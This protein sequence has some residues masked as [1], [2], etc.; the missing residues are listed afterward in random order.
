MLW[1]RS[2]TRA[3]HTAETTVQNHLAW[4][5]KLLPIL[6][7]HV[8]RCCHNTFVNT[9][10]AAARWNWQT[11]CQS[12]TTWNYAGST[13]WASHGIHW[14][15]DGWPGPGGM[16]G[17]CLPIGLPQSEL[18][19]CLHTSITNRQRNYNATTYNKI[20]GGGGLQ[21]FVGC[22]VSNRTERLLT[23][24]SAMVSICTARFRTETFYVLPTQCICFVRISGA[25]NNN[26]TYLGLRGRK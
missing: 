12:R 2:V 17:H 3:Q 7:L 25:Q 13:S 23:P 6:L 21:M 11:A 10:V 19:H 4:R 22:A 8:N 26:N 24:K 14:V 15:A 1:T 5:P 18:L 20:R 16:S 9:F